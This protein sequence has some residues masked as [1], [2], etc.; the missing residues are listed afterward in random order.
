MPVAKY[1][2]EKYGTK[3]VPVEN[4]LSIDNIDIADKV[5]L[6]ND[7]GRFSFTFINLSAND[8]YLR[9][10]NAPTSTNGIYLA[11]NGGEL[12]VSADEDFEL[13]TREWHAIASADNSAFYLLT[14]V[15][16]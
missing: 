4:P 10:S 14:E 12:S 11:A 3:I 5:I 2:Q 8:M 13:V 1:I 6:R 9:P 15:E 7:P 16:G